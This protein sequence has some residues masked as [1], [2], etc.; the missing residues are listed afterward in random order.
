MDG[1]E[2][3]VVMGGVHGRVNADDRAIPFR[4]GCTGASV[5]VPVLWVSSFSRFFVR[6]A[7]LSRRTLIADAEASVIFMVT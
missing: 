7:N 3:I 1:Q 2:S 4:A 5:Q 6:D